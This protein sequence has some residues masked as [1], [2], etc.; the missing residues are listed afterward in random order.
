MY[1]YTTI[2][3]NTHACF[4]HENKKQNI[5]EKTKHTWHACMHNNKGKGKL[6]IR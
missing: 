2:T 1:A 4:K 3:T 6:R 5:P